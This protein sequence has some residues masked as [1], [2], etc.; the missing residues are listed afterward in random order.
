[1]RSRLSCFTLGPGVAVGE[2]GRS[3]RPS[4]MFRG[5][6]SA[7]TAATRSPASSRCIWRRFLQ[8]AE[9]A[10]GD[11]DRLLERVQRD[12]RHREFRPLAF[13]PIPAPAFPHRAMAHGVGSGEPP[14]A[15]AS[16][17]EPAGAAAPP[18]QVGPDLSAWSG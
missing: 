13:E 11:L 2:V 6:R 17:P 1:M 4:P 7:A 15:S 16:P 14:P 18:E 5:R 12:E 8:A 10:R 3:A 9:G